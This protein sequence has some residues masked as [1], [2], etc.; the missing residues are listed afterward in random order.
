MV[1]TVS[2]GGDFMSGRFFAMP[3]L[4]AA[5]IVVP[6]IADALAPDGPAPDWCVY[7][8]MVPMVPV[9][10]SATYDGAWPW[11]S[12][13]GIKDERGHYHQGTNILFFSP[14]RALPDFVWVR[15]GTS[16]RNGAEKVSVQGSIGLFGLNAGPDKFIVDR[17]A[18][19][20]PLLARL[21]VSPGVYFDF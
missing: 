10:T 3:F 6:A 13:N 2:V 7:N 20:D 15:E 17:N 1:Y 19:S 12:Q 21:P 16:F 11:R 4:L 5:M 18:L 9:K 8:L 14:F